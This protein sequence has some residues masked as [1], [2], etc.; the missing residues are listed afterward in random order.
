MVKRRALIVVGGAALLLA[1]ATPPLLAGA[2]SPVLGS[3]TTAAPNAGAPTTEP[4]D[5]FVLPAGFTYLV[6]DTNRITVAVPTT[7]TDIS[8]APS[9]V[10]GAL[11]PSINAATDLDVW[12]RTF[13]AP[14]V[15]YAAFPFTADTQTLM[16]RLG[17]TS[18]CVSDTVVPYSDGVF[19]GSWAQWTECGATGQ[20]AWHLIVASPADQA[21]TAAVVMQLSGPQDQQAFEVVLETF[22]TTPSATWPASAPGPSTTLPP[23]TVG[24]TTVPGP[25]TTGL[26]A[27]G[28]RLVDETTFLT[29]TVPADWTDQ[30]LANSRHDDG[31]ERATITASPDI[32]QYYE[33]WEGSGTH[34]LALPP[35]TDPAVVL[36]QFAYPGA[37]ADG[38]ITLYRDGR[39]TGQR[40]DWSNCDGL[41]TRV[42]NVAARPLDGSF[43]LFIQVQQATPD[44]AALTQ[45]L[46]SAGPVQG[47]AYPTP[48]ASVPLTPTG[49]VPPELLA[50]PAIP[51]TTVADEQGRLSIS[52]PSTWTDTDV[53]PHLN[54]D[55]TDRPRVAAAPVLDDFYSDWE[56]PG[57][58]VVA[59]PFTSDPSTL[60][61]NLGFADQCSDAGVQSYD[62]GTFTGLMQTWAACGD[63]VSRNVLLALS[64][65]DQSVTVYVEIQLPDQDNTPLQA[66]LSSLRVG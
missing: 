64:P 5:S 23:T 45:I 41:E 39:F 61:R 29:V 13:D 43:T 15:L 58:Q 9:T 12:D 16:D 11:V 28:I 19:T 10:E 62:N 53:G 32:Q 18:G 24:A 34:L 6:D 55:A 54:D 21:F 31:S 7:W 48:V 49:L 40:Q 26:P 35:T 4:G 65:A 44:E 2:E 59:Y 14:G 47:A 63:T 60:L 51:L 66:V 36:N 33:T 30:N 38:G 27:I 37:C 22:N 25:T 46:A 17:L 50:A 57:V 20:A 56:A 3:T 8:T 42:V 1:A 52:V